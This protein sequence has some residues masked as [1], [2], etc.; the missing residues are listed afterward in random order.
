[1]HGTNDGGKATTREC[2][3]RRLSRNA[4]LG[5][6]Y[7][8]VDASCSERGSAAHL[9]IRYGYHSL[10]VSLRSD[11]VHSASGGHVRANGNASD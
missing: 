9:A 6:I 7:S 8:I 10:S 1:M 2:Y 4:R 11:H 5:D 3:A